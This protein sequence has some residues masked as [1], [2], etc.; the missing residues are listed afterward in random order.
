MKKLVYILIAVGLMSC[1][2]EA[3]KKETE[4][5]EAPKEIVFIPFSEAT[6]FSGSLLRYNLIESQ[7]IKPRPVDVWLPEGY[8]ESKTYAVLYMHDGQMLF[9]STTSWNN[10][11]WKVDEWASKLIETNKVKDFIVVAIHNLNGQRWQDLFPEKSFS[12]LSEADQDLINKQSN[13]IKEGSDLNGDNYLKFLVEEL[14]PLVDAQ[15]SVYT[16]KENT[17]VMGSSMGG[18]MSMYA[19]CEYPEVFSGAACLSTHW[20]GANPI[21]NNPLPEA[22]FKY[23]EAY[24]PNPENHK[25]YFDYGTET[26]DA[27]YPKFTPEIN[28]ILKA[29]GYTSD[30]SA[31]LEFKG[32][33]HSENSWNKR[34]DIPLTFLLKK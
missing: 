25:I 16:N 19:I 26:L 4:S 15:F 27:Y 23:L 13:A 32:A 2:N 24:A 11:E 5:I 30:N 18:L 20:E 8:S 17:F 12:N 10:Q 1:K 6:L 31:N 29:R 14:K 21:D 22:I 33:D 34:L 28:R 7:Y 9:D 3:S